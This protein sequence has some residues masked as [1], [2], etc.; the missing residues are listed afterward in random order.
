M[1]ALVLFAGLLRPLSVRRLL[2]VGH[3]V[4]GSAYDGADIALLLRDA[5]R[6]LLHLLATIDH[7]RVEWP[8]DVI[9]I[10]LVHFMCVSACGVQ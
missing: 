3:R 6:E 9:R 10:R 1:L 2:L 7:E 4:P 5:R 8:P